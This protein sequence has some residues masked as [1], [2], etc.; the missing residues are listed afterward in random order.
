MP[1]RKSSRRQRLPWASQPWKKS[2]LLPSRSREGSS[3][4]LLP[5]SPSSSAAQART[6]CQGFF[7]EAGC[8]ELSSS[9]CSCHHRGINSEFPDHYSPPRCFASPQAPFISLRGRWGLLPEQRLP[10]LPVH[11]AGSRPSQ[12][13]RQETP[14]CATQ[15]APVTDNVITAPIVPV[16]ICWWEEITYLSELE[17]GM[18]ENYESG[19]C[20]CQET[21]AI[22]CINK[23][24]FSMVVLIN[25]KL[26]SFLSISSSLHG[27]KRQD[28]EEVGWRKAEPY[29]DNQ[30]WAFPVPHTGSSDTT[31]AV[32]RAQRVQGLCSDNN[33]ATKQEAL[34]DPHAFAES[35]NPTPSPQKSTHKQW[36]HSP[37]RLPIDLQ[38]D[39]PW[40]Q[41]PA[42]P[43]SAELQGALLCTAAFRRKNIGFNHS[44]SNI[45]PKHNEI[46]SKTS[47]SPWKGLFCALLLPSLP[48]LILAS[49]LPL[50]HFL[51]RQVHEPW[52]QSNCMAITQAKAASCPWLEMQ[53]PLHTSYLPSCHTQATYTASSF[54]YQWLNCFPLR[55]A[56]HGTTNLLWGVT[57]F[58][59]SSSHHTDRLHKDAEGMEL[60]SP[61]TKLPPVKYSLGFSAVLRQNSG[62]RFL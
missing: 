23:G 40:L 60:L 49:W 48:L 38:E 5:P 31:T 46:C 33:A 41:A 2:S 6:L 9:W 56:S 17:Q 50:S 32:S 4:R 1:C 42:E 14:R 28:G 22:C 44:S 19:I 58:V 36:G 51:S 18:L 45:L 25:S 12:L 26:S 13:V 16:Y 43:F 54:T 59:F 34:Q 11:P 35:L 29:V 3:E 47:Y 10:P 57:L 55:E 52:L 15:L 53:P 37:G 7:Q 20:L 39:M 62:N 21:S 24:Y 8:T 27:S 30:R 61:M